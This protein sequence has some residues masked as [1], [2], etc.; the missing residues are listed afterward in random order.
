[1]NP[2]ACLYVKYDLSESLV[3]RLCLGTHF[4]RLCLAYDG[5]IWGQS[6]RIGVTRQSLV[7]SKIWGA[8]LY[9]K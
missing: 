2:G 6:L 9:I 1:M 7:T 5:E 3:P 8:C 4:Q